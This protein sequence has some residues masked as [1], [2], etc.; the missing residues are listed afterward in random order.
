MNEG[1]PSEAQ[2]LRDIAVLQQASV[3]FQHSLNALTGKIDAFNTQNA[4]RFEAIQ[5][6]LAARDRPD[7]QRYISLALLAAV[8]VGGGWTVLSLHTENSVLKNV[9]PLTVQTS[10]SAKDRDDMRAAIDDLD[11][12]ADTNSVNIG[13]INRDLREVETQFCSLSDQ[14]NYR[15]LSTHRLLDQLWRKAF[16]QPLANYEA[17]PRVGRCN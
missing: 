9:M 15:L 10:T 13:E 17:T 3:S 2:I 7:W 1:S 14:M 12:V 5:Q 8:L 16:D 4:T 11:N 6:Q